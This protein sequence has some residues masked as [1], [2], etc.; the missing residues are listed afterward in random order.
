MEGLGNYSG[1]AWSDAYKTNACNTIGA[2]EQTS[3]VDWID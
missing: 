2:S 1:T 3:F